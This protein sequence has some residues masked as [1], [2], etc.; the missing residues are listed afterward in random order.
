MFTPH[1][2]DLLGQRRL[3]LLKCLDFGTGVRRLAS[4][5]DSRSRK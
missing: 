1:L 2:L 5:V 3:L 4:F